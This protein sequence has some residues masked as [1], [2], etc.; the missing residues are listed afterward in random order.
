M[1]V[2]TGLCSAG[3]S[4]GLYSALHKVL[5]G[6]G[7][8]RNGLGNVTGVVLSSGVDDDKVS[9]VPCEW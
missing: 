6:L 8:S 3:S 5:L 1:F 9:S 2:V 7:I 4:F